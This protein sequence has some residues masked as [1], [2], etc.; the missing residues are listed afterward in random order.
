PLL[1][2]AFRVH[3]RT[4]SKA[5]TRTTT[6]MRSTTPQWD[7]Q[8]GPP[9][10]SH[11]EPTLAASCTPLSSTW[12]DW[13][14][15]TK[16]SAQLSEMMEKLEKLLLQLAKENRAGAQRIRADSPRSRRRGGP[17]L[18]CLY[19]KSRMTRFNNLL[20]QMN[21]KEVRT[22]VALLHNAKS[23]T[24]KPTEARDNVKYL[25][26]LDKFFG[27]LSKCQPVTMQEH[28]PALI[29]RYQDDLHDL[30][31]LQHLRA[32]MTTLF[33]KVT[34]QMITTAKPT[35]ARKSL[36]ERMQQ[37]LGVEP[38][39]PGHL[40]QSPGAPAPESARETGFEFSENYIFGKVRHVLPRGCTRS[41]TCCSVVQKPQRPTG[42]QDE[43]IE[44]LIVRYRTISESIRQENLRHSGPSRRLTLTMTTKRLFK[45]NISL[46]LWYAYIDNM[47][48]EAMSAVQQLGILVRFE[49][50]EGIQFDWSEKYTRILQSYAKELENVRRLYQRYKDEPPVARNLR[51]RSPAK[52]PLVVRHLLHKIEKPM[53]IF[54]HKE[55]GKSCNCQRPG[56]LFRN[57]NKMAEVLLAFELLLPS[58]GLNTV[59]QFHIGLNSSSARSQLAHRPPAGSTWIPWRMIA[60]FGGHAA[61]PSATPNP[62]SDEAAFKRDHIN[63]VLEEPGLTQLSCDFKLKSRTATHIVADI[64]SA[65][66]EVADFK[67]LVKQLSDMIE[68]RV[69]A[70]L[71][72]MSLTALV[73]L[74]EEEPVTPE[75]FVS[76]TEAVCND[77]AEFLYKQSQLVESS[78]NE[79]VETILE[80][81][82][83]T[84]KI[85]RDDT[86]DCTD[87]SARIKRQRCQ[88]APLGG[89]ALP[90]PGEEKKPALFKSD[91]VL[92]LPNITTQPTL[93][94][95]Q[96]K[97]NKAWKHQI[98]TQK[99]LQRK[100]QEDSAKAEGKDVDRM[101]DE[102]IE[103]L[104]LPAEASLSPLNKIIADH[105]DVAKL[106]SQMSSLISSNKIDEK[107]TFK[108]FY[109]FKQLW[110]EEINVKV[111]EFMDRK[112]I[113]SEISAVFK[114]NV[115]ME[116]ELSALPQSYQDALIE[117]CK[118][119]RLAYGKELNERCA[120][121]HGRHP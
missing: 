16:E 21:R 35:F 30:A 115:D 20:E 9:P 87:E 96:H 15:L 50:I 5:I 81:L 4:T 74:P 7:A 118:A 26:T 51:R 54:K 24:L 72:E 36:V 41:W 73:D 42:H 113:L 59:Q 29:K 109:K 43:G 66:N 79:A 49:R 101:T 31:V 37:L 114:A 100:L 1:G 107:E 18:S 19:W 33:V 121:G 103:E 23:R 10:G 64:E 53:M 119:W 95:I 65:R 52:S 34:N 47:V 78:V 76:M 111:K 8:R 99:Q 110:M 32:R 84:K 71:E 85:A 17:R 80:R 44:Q 69:E 46:R 14:S 108:E 57:Y 28:I 116:M 60:E 88:D 58:E 105:K 89:S 12:K 102:E 90:R 61:T 13:G 2:L 55:E 68:C 3:S 117:E 22:V 104:K 82:P 93:E 48:Q 25:Y 75:E 40:P 70:V 83:E 112:P 106:M 62:D 39:L 63:E 45:Q 98:L 94:E 6:P 56:R 91:V 11:G 92:Q 77:A 27:P 120:Q 67:I 97:F 38:P 86:W